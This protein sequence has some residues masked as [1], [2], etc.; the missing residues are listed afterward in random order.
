MLCDAMSDDCDDCACP[1][2]SK[3][4]SS[5]CHMQCDPFNDDAYPFDDKENMQ[6]PF[7]PSKNDADVS[8]YE[9]PSPASRMCGEPSLSR[10]GYRPHRRPLEDQDPNSQ[11]SG[12]GASYGGK[13]SSRMDSFEM[14]ALFSMEDEFLDFSDMTPLEDNQLPE[15]INKLICNTLASDQPSKKFSPRSV[16]PPLRRAI[17]AQYGNDTP[18]STAR[19]CLFKIQ[20]DTEGRS[21]RRSEHSGGIQIK[22]PRTFIDDNV[23]I[24]VSRSVPATEDSI[25]FALQRSSNEPDLI[26][27]F[28]KTFCLPLIPGRHNDLKSI[29]PATLALLLKGHFKNNVSTF[30]VI[31]CRY[32][33][34]YEAG[35]I[36]GAVNIYTKDQCLELFSSNNLPAM[37]N[38]EQ[39]RHI[40]VFHCEFSSERG[41]N[42]SRYLRTVDRSQNENS[43]PSLNYPEVYLLDGGYKSFYEQFAELCT[44]QAY[45]PMLHPEHEKDM[46]HF[47][48]KSKTWNC[49]V[50]SRGVPRQG[51]YKKLRFS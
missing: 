12:Y 44:P 47:R 19:S 37:D 48:A 39:M 40:L 51:G 26:G 24:A 25:K 42:L 38:G 1:S 22:R 43:Y 21:C 45:K 4:N 6:Q 16:R 14:G 10:C 23:P 32:P 31:D 29:T 46:R 13:S 35:H 27:D 7:S 28:S 15:N 11:D 5:M 41:P 33:Y 2:M 30:R 49:D 3:D 50:R 36:T 8:L 9:G 18:T 17:S 34:E 20:E